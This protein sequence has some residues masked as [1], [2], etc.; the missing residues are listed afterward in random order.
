MGDLML[1]ESLPIV[2][3]FSL[4]SFLFG[5]L[6]ATES[7]FNFLFTSFTKEPWSFFLACA[8]F[9]GLFIAYKELQNY[10][11]RKLAESISIFN[12]ETRRV[13]ED[14]ISLSFKIRNQSQFYYVLE[15]LNISNIFPTWSAILYRENKKTE[16]KDN[17]RYWTKG[18]IKSPEVSTIAPAGLEFFELSITLTRPANTCTQTIK[19]AI[20]ESGILVR[21]VYLHSNKARL[22]RMYLPKDWDKKVEENL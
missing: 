22:I 5:W 15:D 9:I 12:I 11:E 14:H 8:S 10:E 3:I 21:P 6:F 1:K 13:D 16:Q 17:T 20:E 2:V 4:G 7:I 19:K 18:L